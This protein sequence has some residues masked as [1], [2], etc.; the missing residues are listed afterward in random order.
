MSFWLYLFHFYIIPFYSLF[1]FL[2]S[3]STPTLFFSIFLISLCSNFPFYI[4]FYPVI[5]LSSLA[6]FLCW[7]SICIPYCFCLTPY[8]ILRYKWGEFGLLTTPC[9]SCHIW[10]SCCCH[11]SVP[12]SI[13]LNAPPLPSLSC[14]GALLPL[15]SQSTSALA[16]A[17]VPASL[18]RPGHPLLPPTRGRSLCTSLCWKIRP[19]LLHWAS[20][21]SPAWAVPHPGAVIPT[22]FMALPV[23]TAHR[24]SRS[25]VSSPEGSLNGYD[26]LIFLNTLLHSHVTLPGRLHQGLLPCW[27]CGQDPLFILRS[28]SMSLANFVPTREKLSLL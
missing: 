17:E 1:L 24:C 19:L 28:P 23:T 11:D 25:Q 14:W 18:F 9:V 26:D 22:V 3:S 16:P 6:L 8:L 2:F 10:Y 13:S 5:Y 21:Q 20:A 12:P 27:L 4:S 7:F 15:V